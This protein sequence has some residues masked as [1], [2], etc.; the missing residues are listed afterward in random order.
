MGNGQGATGV[1][2]INV[3]AGALISTRMLADPDGDPMT[4]FSI[5]DSG[6]VVLDAE[7]VHIAPGARI[8]THVVAGSRK[9]DGVTIPE[10]GAV[11]LGDGEGG[12]YGWITTK[13]REVTI[14]SATVGTFDPSS[15]VDGTEN[16]IDLGS[17]HGL[18]AGD[19]VRYFTNGGAA[20]GGLEDGRTYFAIVLEDGRVQLAEGY[21]KALS[22]DAIDIS[23]G[24][25]SG[26]G[27][28]VVKGVVIDAS[29]DPGGTAG[30]VT[31]HA[32]IRPVAVHTPVLDFYVLESRIDISGASIRGGDVVIKSEAYARAPAPDGWAHGAVVDLLNLAQSIPGAV[33]SMITGVTAAV[34]VRQVSATVV[35]HD[36][37]VISSGTVTISSDALSRSESHASATSLVKTPNPLLMAVAVSYTESTAETLLTGTTSIRAVGDV[38]VK[39][40]G[41]CYSA[42]MA[43]VTNI[44]ETLARRRQPDKFDA[45]KFTAA[46]TLAITDLT[47]RTTVGQDAEIIS[48][49]GNVDVT[50]DGRNLIWSVAQNRMYI[51]ARASLV[52]TS[53]VAL[54]EVEAI[55]DGRIVAAGA[56]R[57]GESAQFDSGSS[58]SSGGA[59][60]YTENT[61]RIRDHGFTTGDRI[62]YH[63]EEGAES[64]LGGLEDGETYV[65]LVVDEDTVQ[66][67]RVP[68]ID[69][70]PEEAN[71]TSQHRLVSPRS[72]AFVLNAVDEE[73]DAIWLPGHRFADGDVVTYSHDSVFGAIE[74]LVNGNEYVVE[75]DGDRIKLRSVTAPPGA[76]PIVLSQG[77]ALGTHSFTTLDGT[78]Y[79]LELGRI[80]ADS[81]TVH[82]E[83][84]GLGSALH[85]SGDYL[86]GGEAGLSQLLQGGTYAIEMVDDPLLPA[87]RSGNRLDRGPDRR[88]RPQHPRDRLPGH[89]YAEDIPA[90][91]RHGRRRPGHDPDRESRLRD[92]RCRVLRDRPGRGHA[93][94][95]AGGGHGGYRDCRRRPPSTFP[96]RRLAV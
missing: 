57:D 23:A 86:R 38:V 75:V 61:I 50:A 37:E 94:G 52:S 24:A 67:S 41:D 59:V 40:E 71:S 66:L 54:S 12:D 82:V 42:P 5:G 72:T 81:D 28:R 29:G 65:V 55:V 11:T 84:H 16:T 76:P 8:L 64:A 69:L 96:I 93:E 88:R 4:A 74:G 13:T 78:A 95:R 62:V 3:A 53:V 14:Q 43:R 25:A 44:L 21:Q 92:R 87:P 39:A 18:E 85:G 70:G 34:S 35:L 26:T 77:N 63:A 20:I 80:D 58:E 30:A 31:I 33:L 22:G 49:G 79:D 56:P 83:N 90:G 17:E 19:A 68:P 45:S 7:I 36:T 89:R 27:H 46:I 48:T 51:G 2:V 15:S 47:V 73:A 9:P 91:F 6:E 1:D 60:D 10:A 32:V